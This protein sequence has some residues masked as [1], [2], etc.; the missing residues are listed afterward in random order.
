MEQR[1][2]RATGE[3]EPDEKQDRAERFVPPQVH[4]VENDEH[5]FHRR[6]HDERGDDQPFHKRQIDRDDLDAGD[7]GEEH[8]DLHVDV[9]F[10]RIVPVIVDGGGGDSVSAHVLGEV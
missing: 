9:E 10:V 5:E 3:D 8:R 7:D 1:P 6:E 2:H 4:E